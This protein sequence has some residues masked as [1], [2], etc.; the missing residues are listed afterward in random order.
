M[1][2]K[3]KECVGKLWCFTTEEMFAEGADEDAFTYANY[4]D[5]PA[6]AIYDASKFEE[7]AQPEVYILKKGVTRK[8]ALLNVLLLVF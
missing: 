6:I 3:G 1:L 5:L 4:Y 2:K 7:G 8:G